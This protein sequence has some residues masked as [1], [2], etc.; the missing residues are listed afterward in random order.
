[1]FVPR[2]QDPSSAGAAQAGGGDVGPAAFEVFTDILYRTDDAGY[3][4][5]GYTHVF[6]VAADEARRGK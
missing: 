4:K 1:M 2:R 3:L 5:P 6:V